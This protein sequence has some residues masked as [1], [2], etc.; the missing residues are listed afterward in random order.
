MLCTSQ[1]VLPAVDTPTHHSTKRKTRLFSATT[2]THSSGHREKKYIHLCNCMDS[3]VLVLCNTAQEA[4]AHLVRW[5]PYT[6]Q[7]LC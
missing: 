3:L 6:C 2:H 7:M 5:C 1:H 4:S